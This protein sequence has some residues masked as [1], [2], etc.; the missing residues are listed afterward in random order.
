MR[1]FALPKLA[2][3]IDPTVYP[4]PSRVRTREADPMPPLKPRQRMPRPPPTA[5]SSKSSP[6]SSA[7]RS[8]S[9][10]SS[11]V[12]WK[13]LISFSPPS[14][15]SV[16]TG[17][18]VDVETPMS[19][20][21]SSIYLIKAVDAVPTENVF[22]MMIGVSIVPSSAIWIR[23]ALLPKPFMTAHPAAT[24]SR[25]RFPVCG[26]IAVTPVFTAS[27]PLPPVKVTFATRTPGTSVILSRLPL[28]K[29]L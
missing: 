2:I 27:S 4:S 3:T 6:D 5:P 16:T 28:L 17:F 25:K 14:L 29:L 8:A 19:L 20:F 12:T 10:T 9:R 15:H 7:F 11:S 13:P 24:F 23:P 18:T 21:C 22:V 26:S 1:C